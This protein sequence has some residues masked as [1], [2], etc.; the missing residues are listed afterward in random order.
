M[1][2]LL[3]DDEAAK[4][5]ENLSDVLD[6]IPDKLYLYVSEALAILDNAKQDPL[7]ALTD[8]TQEMGLYE[9]AQPAQPSSFAIDPESKQP[10]PQQETTAPD[11]MQDWK[12]YW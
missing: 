11:N 9:E 10:A 3:T 4:V 2:Y 8:L 6:T 7:Q 5:R 12:A 1:T